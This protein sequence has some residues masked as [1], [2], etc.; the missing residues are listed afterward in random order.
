MFPYAPAEDKKKFTLLEGREFRPLPNELTIGEFARTWFQGWLDQFCDLEKKNDYASA[1]R[2]ILPVFEYCSFSDLD[3]EGINHFFVGFEAQR[4]KNKGKSASTKRKRN[5][6][7]VFKRIWSEA[8]GQYGWKLPDPFTSASTYI[9]EADKADK[10]RRAV[11]ATLEELISD[12]TDFDPR[13][14]FL[15]SEWRL[16]LDHIAPFYRPVT[17]FLVL[18]MMIGSE[19]E[20]LPKAC[21]SG[22]HIRVRVKRDKSGRILPILKTEARERN[23][24]ITKK[25]REV[26]DTAMKQSNSKFLF[27][28][29]DGSDFDYSAYIMQ[30]W[31]KAINDAGLTHRVGYSARHTGIAWHML[32][33]VD[34]ERMIRIAGHADKGM[35][36][37]RYGRY[38]DGLYEEREELLAYMGSDVLLAD[39]LNAFR[40]AGIRKTEEN[41]PAPNSKKAILTP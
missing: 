21:V 6:L 17:E 40:E 39:E 2:R 7:Y 24:P 5:V 28:M 25:L 10:I 22:E 16:L 27:F 32:L 38:T 41:A 15:L 29:E 8:C 23:I 4:G 20:A 12:D 11:T 9:E 3:T 31:S 37:G 19:V 18:T 14:T 36:Y 26:I 30:V 1:L 33:K 34:H 35:I 13:Q